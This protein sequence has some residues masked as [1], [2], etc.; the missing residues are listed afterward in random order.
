MRFFNLIQLLSLAI[1]SGQVLALPAN[2]LE[3][4]EARDIGTPT[5]SEKHGLATQHNPS[6]PVAAF[7]GQDQNADPQNPQRGQ[8]QDD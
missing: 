8:D 6:L 1:A 4:L 2:P 5:V 7:G 3:H